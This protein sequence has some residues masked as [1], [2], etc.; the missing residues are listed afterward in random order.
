MKKHIFHIVILA[1]TLLI[2]LNAENSVNYAKSALDLCYNMIIPTLFPFFIC[3]GLLV[4]SG[5]CE[6]LA[7]LTAPIMKPLFHIN[8]SGSS[9][10]ILGIISGYPL[11]AITACQLYENHYLSKTEAE[12]LL[13]FCNNSGPLFILGS[14]GIALYSGIKV[15]IL[16]YLT[17]LLAALTVGI[18]FRFYKKDDYIAPVT[19][20]TNQDRPMGEIFSIVL[21]N[22]IQNIFTVCATVLFFSVVSRL[23][24][25]L[26]P[27][28]GSFNALVNGIMEFVTGTVK[29]NESALLFSQKMVL[30]ALIVGFA[31]F[32]VHMQVLGVV[33]RY[34]LSLKPYLFGKAL[35]GIL[36]AI[37]TFLFLR[38]VPFEQPAFSP[39]ISARLSAGFATGSIYTTVAVCC[40]LAICLVCS[41]FLFMHEL[42]HVK[43]EKNV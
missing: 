7:R 1:I 42:E 2:I 17:H 33:S 30:S 25:D 24:L 41:F 39:D 32:S 43:K 14:V 40:V 18:L 4:Y 13:A 29:I 23:V 11:G 9:A 35:H 21:Q 5:F 19:T 8:P 36:A 37:Y 27:L 28:E 3:S 38:F 6:T 15:G 26:F 12:R 10:F 20:V 34:E 31:G 16:L 22:S